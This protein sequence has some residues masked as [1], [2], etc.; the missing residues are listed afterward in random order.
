MRTILAI[1]FCSIAQLMWGYN[2][3]DILFQESKSSQSKY[4][5]FATLSS[6]THCGVIYK[7]GGKDYVLEA[8]GKVRLTPVDEWIAREVGKKVKVRK[9]NKKG[10][11][12]NLRKYLGKAYDTSFSWDD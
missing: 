4:I 10:F 3:G 9:C 6:Y 12:I 7:K 1:I 11:R 5:K 2:Q 8:A